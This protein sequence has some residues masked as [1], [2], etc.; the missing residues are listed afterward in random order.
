MMVDVV[1]RRGRRDNYRSRSRAQQLLAVILDRVISE[2]IAIGK[3]LTGSNL[4][5]ELPCAG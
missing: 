3:T 5:T 1:N 4:E 2:R